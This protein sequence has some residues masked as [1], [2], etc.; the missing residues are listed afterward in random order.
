MASE[1]SSG[2]KSVPPCKQSADI[3]CVTDEEMQEQL[4]AAEA[5]AKRGREVAP[6]YSKAFLDALDAL[7]EPKA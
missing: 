7:D 4:R 5:W 1:P 3:A 6:R 2:E